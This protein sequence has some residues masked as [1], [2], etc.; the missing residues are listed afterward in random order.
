MAARLTQDVFVRRSQQRHKNKYDYSKVVYVT[1][2]DKVTI[3]CPKHGPFQQPPADHM[4][5]C[6][7]MLCR[8]ER[9]SARCRMTQEEFVKRATK[10]HNGKYT[11][12]KTKYV[13]FGLHVIVTCLQHGD[14]SVDPHNHLQGNG[15]R[16]CGALSRAKDR[17]WTTSQ[18]VRE[19]R[20]VHGF[21]Y[22]YSQTKYIRS[23]DPVV[24]VCKI[25]GPFEQ[26]PVVHIRGK[27][28]CPKCNGGVAMTQE[29]FL[30]RSKTKFPHLDYSRVKYVNSQTEVN[31]GCPKHGFYAQL[32]TVHLHVSKIGCPRCGGTRKYTTREFVAAAA[33]KHGGKYDYSQSVYINNKTKTRIGCPIHG[34]F[35]QSPQMHLMGHG[36]DKCGGTAKVTVEEYKQKCETKFGDLFDYSQIRQIESMKQEVAIICKEHGLFISPANVHLSSE[37]GCPL[38]A[39]RKGGVK[40][41]KQL[42]LPPNSRFVVVADDGKSDQCKRHV[43]VVQCS[44]PLKTIME[45]TVI[46]LTKKDRP[47]LS[48]G[49]FMRERAS[50]ANMFKTLRKYFPETIN[51]NNPDVWD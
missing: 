41:R 23:S 3:V 43:V 8:N 36:C 37:H 46:D 7:C 24:I 6:G 17:T 14:F 48:C 25:H 51:I 12:K 34:V 5:G 11:Y 18:F 13:K 35:E 21:R 40:R 27:H 33:S 42:T 49:C 1:S 31:I 29:E 9:I 30:S 19:A 15:C 16:K 39:R 10:K 32:P 47:T 38:C 50:E 20:H 22:D 26:K 28:G 45:K 4:N 2:K 44:C